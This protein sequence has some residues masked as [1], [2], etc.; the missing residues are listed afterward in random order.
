MSATLKPH[1][2]G[3]PQVVAEVP[4]EGI[5][6]ARGTTVPADT[7]VGYATGCLF[8]HTD[9]GAGTSLYVNRGSSTSSNFDP[10]TE[11]PQGAALT[12]GLTQLTKL[13]ATGTVFTIPTMITT[14]WG[15]SLAS[16]AEVLLDV[17]VNMQSRVSE[18][19]ARLE[20]ANI[21]AAN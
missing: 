9:G 13:G 2:A 21:V 4:G 11:A 15:F 10:V 6:F 1:Y 20:A 17:V 12:A 18:I 7:S 5:I 19:E 3:N 14:G 16:Q 8:Q